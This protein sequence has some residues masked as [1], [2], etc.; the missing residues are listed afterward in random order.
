MTIAGS[1]PILDSRSGPPPDELFVHLRLD[2]HDLPKILRRYRL[3]LALSI[4]SVVMLFVGF[5]SAYIV[6]RGIS[7]YEA[8]T[9]AYSSSWEPLKLPVAL[10]LVNTLL[11]VGASIAMEIARRKSQVSAFSRER[12]KHGGSGWI[13]FSLLLSLGFVMGQGI[14]WRRLRLTGLFM[15]SGPQTA[16]FYVLTGTHALHAV[17]GIALLAWI[18]VRQRHWLPIRQYVAVDLTAWYLHSMTVLWIYLF[19]FV[20]WA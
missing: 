10:L 17:L 8:A 14:A 3:G 4:A 18:A 6:R 2:R 9:G 5:S 15:S 7:T 13:S 20:M 1:S 16:F 11:L 19:C 12:E